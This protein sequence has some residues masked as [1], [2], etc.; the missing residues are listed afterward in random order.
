MRSS[1]WSFRGKLWGLLRLVR[2]EKLLVVGVLVEMGVGA[3]GRSLHS[4]SALAAIAVVISVLVF[5]NSTND[6]FDQ[7]ADRY[8]KPHRPLPSGRVTE[9]VAWLVTVAALAV[10][11]GI[12]FSLLPALQLFVGLTITGSYLYS[13][14][15]KR[16]PVV[17][18]LMVATLAALTVAF[19]CVATGSMSARV[20]ILA[21]LIGLTILLFELVKTFEDKDGDAHA[22]YH[23]VAHA[24]SPR[25]HNTLIRVFGAIYCLFAIWFAAAPSISTL[26]SDTARAALAASLVIPAMPLFAAKVGEENRKS[27]S[28]IIQT[29]KALWPIL[30]R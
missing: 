27:L 2:F 16:I 30:L 7:K 29:S 21:V 20:G 14:S 4:T 5:G 9:K 18:N 1:T 28:Q 11:L 22:G 8:D 12:T 26:S 10:A 3:S 23:T 24:V 6:I 15:L 17:G 13:V 25:S 19:G